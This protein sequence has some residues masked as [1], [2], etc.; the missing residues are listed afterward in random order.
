MWAAMF[1]SSSKRVVLG[2]RKNSPAKKNI[3]FFVFD[4]F[5]CFVVCLSDFCGLRHSQWCS[6]VVP[7]ACV[8]VHNGFRWESWCGWVFFSRRWLAY[9]PL[10][11]SSEASEA[12]RQVL[13]VCGKVCPSPTSF[14]HV[15][16]DEAPRSFASGIYFLS[17]IR[18][19]SS[20]LRS[21]KTQFLFGASSIRFLVL[22]LVQSNPQCF[23][24]S[25]PHLDRVFL[26]I[27]QFS[28]V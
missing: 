5:W 22:C 28:S 17:E 19:S 24:P 21:L 3:Y 4:V 27:L 8:D 14:Q 16:G 20:Q 11:W 1:W 23:R 9:V 26:F 10:R 25:Q 2:D 6:V 12:R 15:V 7:A 18:I 13:T